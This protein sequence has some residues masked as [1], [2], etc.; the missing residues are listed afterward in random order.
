MRIAVAIVLLLG[1]VCSV[2]GA[3]DAN[4]N[5]DPDIILVSTGPMNDSDDVNTYRFRC[6][7]TLSEVS[8]SVF[9]QKLEYGEENCCKKVLRTYE[10]DQGRLEGKYALYSVSEINWLGYDSFTF[11]ANSTHYSIAKLDSTYT[12][13]RLPARK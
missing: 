6:V 9:I 10:L 7:I 12:I 3:D 1:T 13:D 2:H 5:I 8:L 11:K 4:I